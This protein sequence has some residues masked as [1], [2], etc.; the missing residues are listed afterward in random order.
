MDL[1]ALSAILTENCELQMIV[2]KRGFAP[3]PSGKL[4]LMPHELDVAVN[5]PH[6]SVATQRVAVG[7]EQ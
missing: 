3:L 7:V 6:C 5:D 4:I 2:G 1:R